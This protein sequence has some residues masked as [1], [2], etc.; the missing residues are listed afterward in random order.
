MK[1][2]FSIIFALLIL[3]S[4]PGS[5]TDYYMAPTTASPAGSDANAGTLAAPWAT[6]MKAWSVMTASDDLY[7]RG[8]TYEFTVQQVITGING[9]SG[10]LVQVW[11]YQNEVPIFTRNATTYTLTSPYEEYRGIIFIGNYFHWKGISVTGYNQIDAGFPVAGIRGYDI[12]NGIFELMNCYGNGGQGIAFQGDSWGNLFLNSDFHRNYDPVSGGGNADGLQL[13]YINGGGATNTIRGCRAWWN[14][15]DGF[16]VFENGSNVLIDSCW[17][18]YNGYIPD[19]FTPAGNGQGYKYGSLF[20]FGAT[21]HNTFLRT[22]QNSIAV[23]NSSTGF[24]QEE[25]D[26]KMK[27]FNNLSGYNAIGFNF[28]YTTNNA[29]E[30]RNNVAYANTTDQ[31][32][33]GTNTIESNNSASGTGSLDGWTDDVS[34]DDFSSVSFSSSTLSVARQANGT[35]P[36]VSFIHLVSGS[37][38]VS[39]GTDVSLSGWRNPPDRGAFQFGSFVLIGRKYGKR[40]RLQ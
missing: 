6:L 36:M 7:V 28:T 22:T 18:W 37:S 8:G 34:N 11:A 29:H 40:W 32:F 3:F 14:S 20:N 15:D 1:F 12:Q 30:F 19:T 23:Y 35:L 17:S 16:D 25:A 13:F 10:N 5:C 2:I 38:L 33:L 27:F 24:H 31:N 4:V 21:Y 26:C 9:T 39:A